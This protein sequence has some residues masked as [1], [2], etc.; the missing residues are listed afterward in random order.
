MSVA[1]RIEAMRKKNASL[2]A[3]NQRLKLASVLRDK[4]IEEQN[5]AGVLSE[6]QRDELV[7]LL[8][9]ARYDDWACRECS[10]DMSEYR[11]ANNCSVGAWLRI[12]GGEE[13]VTRQRNAAHEAALAVE[14]AHNARRFDVT[15]DGRRW[16]D[17]NV[18]GPDAIARYGYTLAPPVYLANG[19][20]I[21]V[22]EN[23][24]P[25]LPLRGDTLDANE[26]I[27]RALGWPTNKRG[28]N[29]NSLLRGVT[30]DNA[31]KQKK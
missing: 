25:S 29:V 17:A 4:A 31:D 24:E 9:L 18:G 14:E 1:S 16:I 5:F 2:R 23:S 20:Y 19:A 28:P 30:D 13:E 22:V 26:T 7:E 10:N 3:E 27:K 8:Q 11:H 15:Y 12:L 6:E 21:N